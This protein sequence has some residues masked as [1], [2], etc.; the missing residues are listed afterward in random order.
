[1]T[2]VYCS[3]GH[4]N[5]PDN[6]YCQWCGE[7]LSQHQPAG[8]GIYPGMLLGDR[9]RIVRL[10]GQGGFGRTYLAEDIN[11]FS[12]PC[13]LKEFAP[14]VRGTY[15]LQKAEQLFEREAGTL[16]KLQ[17]SQIPRFRELF[18]FKLQDE[19]HLFLVQDYVEGQTYRGLLE[20]RK[21]QAQR[22]NEAEVQQLLVQILPVLDYIH[23]MGVIH[24]DISPDNLILRNSDSMPIVIDF[25]GVKQVAA[26]AE[27]QFTQAA[28]D[29][30][31]SFAT[32][33]GKVGYAP[34]EQMQMGMV[35]PHSDLYALAATA[36]VLLTGKEPQQ[37]IDQN[38]MSWNWR[39]EINLSPNLSAVLDKMLSYRPG[40]RFQSVR[41][42][43]QALGGTIPPVATLP[44]TQPALP[45]TPPPQQQPTGVT[46]PVAPGHK[47]IP[48]HPPVIQ[49]PPPTPSNNS[50]RGWSS[51]LLTN[52]FV[53]AI[54]VVG[55]AGIGW[56][57]NGIVR[58]IPSA[59]KPTVKPVP[60]KT[61]DPEPA[62][63]QQFSPA[64]QAR[65]ERL[66]DRRRQLGIDYNFYV[67][68]VNEAFWHRN[69]NL[70]GRTL[71][72]EPR[73]EALRER[74][75]AIASELLDKLRL[76]SA[77]ARQRLGFY[78]Q[79]DRDRFKADVNELRLSSRALNDIVDGEFFYRFPEQEG[80]DFLAKP[81]G[82]VWSAI[83]DD[84]VNAIK[85]QTALK[86][87]EFD[88]GATGKQVSGTLEPGKGIAYIAGLAAGQQMRVNLDADRTAL[89]SVYPPTSNQKALLED[90][91]KRSWSGDLS[92]NGFYEFVIVSKAS[93]PINYR[94]NLTAENPAPPA[95]P[96]P[97]SP[98]KP[99]PIPSP[100][101]DR[102][103]TS[104]PTEPPTS[105]PTEP[106]TSSPTAPP[107]SSPTAPPTSP[108]T[109]ETPATDETPTKDV[110]AASSS[111]TPGTTEPAPKQ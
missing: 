99:K 55:I 86:R 109:D 48:N 6:L 47:S 74:W 1:M 30:V 53:I 36:L 70:R 22:F 103:P 24:R 101:V 92:Q 79:A 90:S 59:S 54:A 2:R 82:Q 91:T 16:Y 96:E 3:K 7:K 94:L 52:I 104:P 45:P 75:D 89:F 57:V 107:T 67:S 63:A 78:G 29:N 41:E 15:A 88:P 21:R 17:H 5:A 27:S 108:P 38:S 23:S 19:G 93:K 4:E 58:N 61:P 97:P 65:K 100:S 8:K 105:P 81:M 83:A 25:G 87:I 102:S 110:P 34:N 35:S 49:T 18:R 9:Y 106:P 39:R 13:V 42:V 31:P 46:L 111:P 68:L 12:E 50:D 51:L 80:K 56:V 60:P 11:R 10:L 14:Q 33:L 40:D 62:P 69:P 72:D 44:P 84:K 98:P 73:D 32:R 28:P 66:R 37:L 26:E 20:T 43:M 76:L 64:E 95:T 71:S 77:S 85:S